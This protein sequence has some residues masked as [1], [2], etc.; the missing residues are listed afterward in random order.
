MRTFVKPVSLALALAVALSGV[1]CQSGA[2][3]ADGGNG[4]L[5]ETQPRSAQGT[6]QQ[7]A[8]NNPVQ[9][10]QVKIVSVEATPGLISGG[11]N[12]TLSIT[13]TVLTARDNQV[14]RV[15]EQRRV[16]FRQ[17]LVANLTGTVARKPGTYTSRMPIRLPNYADT[18][19]YNYEATI[20]A[21][22]TAPQ[23]MMTQFSVK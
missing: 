11:G 5:R 17:T 18:G 1:A 22:G 10:T 14:V 6:V 12:V 3:L 2:P 13:Y 7:V 23:S 21:G 8:Y 4:A 9:G 20:T 19:L 16:S 15:T